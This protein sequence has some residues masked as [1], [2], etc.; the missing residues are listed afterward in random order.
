MSAGRLPKAVPISVTPIA[1]G[2]GS[3]GVSASYHAKPA[4]DKK[5]EFIGGLV[6]VDEED[7]VVT[8]PGEP[9]PDP[10][11]PTFRLI[12]WNVNGPG[13]TD[14]NKVEAIA[15]HL[16]GL[17]P[18]AINLTE[19]RA[20]IT[21]EAI[22]E[23]LRF[24]T[25]SRWDCYFHEQ[26]GRKSDGLH[27]A[28]LWR[29]DRVRL[30]S[31][32]R[33]DNDATLSAPVTDPD[34]GKTI[35]LCLRRGY[36]A[37]LSLARRD[38]RKRPI[39]L[40]GVHLQSLRGSSFSHYKRQMQARIVRAAMQRFLR[41][42]DIIIAGDLNSAETD[43]AISPLK[44]R[45]AG[46]GGRLADHVAEKR[47]EQVVPS[48]QRTFVVETLRALDVAT[49]RLTL[50]N[51]HRDGAPTWRRGGASTQLDHVLY[52]FEK[53]RGD[54]PGHRIAWSPDRTLSDHAAVM[55]TFEL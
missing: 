18:D 24:V 50:S 39:A 51:T 2:R 29:T 43:A 38:Q 44:D 7:N 53:L 4:A 19:L 22:A 21:A 6:L 36:L 33:F 5:K 11:M 32:K 52:R 37:E 40:A 17:F 35:M 34:S 12:T 42:H 26:R 9:A 15:K 49:P 13:P 20:R 31:V 48:S 41:T 30:D 14:N 27:L 23:Q 16:A 47:W 28:L 3:G 8:P 25:G 46:R 1:T 10:S 45:S 55:A 54:V